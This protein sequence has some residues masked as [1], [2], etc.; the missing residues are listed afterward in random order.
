MQAGQKVVCINDQF[1]RWVIIMY[2]ELPMKNN[3]YTIASVSMGRTDPQDIDVNKM[4]MAVTLNEIKNPIDPHYKGGQQ[5][6]QFVASRFKVL[7]EVAEVKR[8]TAQN[9]S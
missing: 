3:V 4:E 5:E 9:V 2:E 8:R 7:E 6:L 1:D